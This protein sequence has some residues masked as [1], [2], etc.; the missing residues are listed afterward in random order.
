MKFKLILFAALLFTGGVDAQ[1]SYIRMGDIYFRQFN[2][3]TALSYYGRAIKKDSSNAHVRQNIA[4]SYRH[5]NDWGNAER[6]YFKLA[7]DPTAPP[8]DK[9]YYAEALRANQKYAEAEEAFKR[10]MATAPNDISAKERIASADHVADLSKDKHLYTIEN[11]PINTPLSDFGPSFY[12]NGQIFFCSNRQPLGRILIKDNWTD[13]NFLNIYIGKPDANGNITSV[14]SMRGHAVN[15]K[16]HEGPAVYNDKLQEIYIT[17]SNYKNY[18]VFKSSDKA[19]KLK[20]YRLVYLPSESRWGDELIEAV[21]FNDRE[22]SVG[23]ATLTVDAQTLYFASDKP[24][25]YGGVDIYKSVRDMGGN[26][27]AP[28]NLGPT[29]NTSGDDMFPFIADDGI[30]YFASDGRVGLGGLDVYLS[31]PT[32][33]GWSNPVNLG[34]PINTNSDD[35]GFII[36]KDDKSGYFVSNR[37]GGHGDDDIYKFTKKGI[38]ICG[39][40]YDA[41]T[42]DPID[43]SKVVMYEVKDEKGSKL[44]AKD[45]S[46]CFEGTPMR[47]YKFL[48]TKEGYLSNEKTVE[49]IDQSGYR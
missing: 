31:S 1:K 33:D 43:S 37:A 46:F 6:W 8:L 26:W 39:L 16:Y 32:A 25:G 7:N 28:V 9:M 24:G 4:D 45:G 15:G 22:Y 34:F 2:F 44:T 10:Y 49:T 41:K 30:L 21:P 13:A 17:R 23:H 35:F 14:N 3:K 47:T 19:V 36:D 12:T 18:K 40:V 11:L 42:N 20:L 29:I 38:D 5:L 48:A 27:T